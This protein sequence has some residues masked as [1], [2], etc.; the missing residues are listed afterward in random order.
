VQKAADVKHSTHLHDPV[1]LDALVDKVLLVG[2]V[3][4]GLIIRDDVGGVV[5]PVVAAPRRVEGLEPL[6]AGLLLVRLGC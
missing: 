2:Q 3:I 4:L 5:L 6:I 1:D